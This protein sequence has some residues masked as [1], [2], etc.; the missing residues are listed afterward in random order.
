[1]FDMVDPYDG[2]W[3]AFVPPVPPDDDAVD[4][5]ECLDPMLELVAAQAMDEYHAVCEAERRDEL[6]ADGILAEVA[7][8]RVRANL[9]L[10][11][12]LALAAR[13]ADLHGVLDPAVIIPGA[14]R[15]VPIGGDG[16]PKIAEFAPAEFGAMLAMGDN[17]AG[18][19]IGDALDL[20]H[21]F[22]LLWERDSDRYRRCVAGPQDR[23]T[24]PAAVQ[25][26]RRHGRRED[27][28]AG[29]TL[30]WG[31]LRKVVDAAILEADPPKAMDDAE[32]AASQSGARVVDDLTHGYQTMIINAAA[33]DIKA[34]NDI[35]NE[36]SRALNIL[37]DTRPRQQ[38]RASAAG[39]LA[40][41]Q[42]ALDLLAR[43]EQVRKAQLEAAAAR[44][45]G[46]L[47]LAE[48][49]E[50][51]LAELMLTDPTPMADEST[52]PVDEPAPQPPRCDRKPLTFNT[53]V[54]YYHLTKQTLDA[55][56]NGEPFAGA[57][58]VRM[59]DIG[60]VIAEQVRQWLQHSNVTVKPVIDLAGIPPVDRYEVP[61]RISEA[62]G[63]INPADY[64]PYATNLS[65]HQ[66]NDHTTPYIPMNKGGPPGQT[67]PAKMGK[68]TKRHH[69]IKTHSG[70]RVEQVAAGNWL[71]RSPHGYHFLVH[72]NGTTALGKL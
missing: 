28:A 50:Q 13:W 48:R 8:T 38:R 72:P 55:M 44:R 34:L 59:E 33:G 60:P 20:R 15:L 29:R 40:H 6:D 31:R 43:A 9:L 35:L 26:S 57:G 70:W 62:I 5:D 67:D 41:P 46:D 63:L 2:E 27:R 24:G 61:D 36:L 18:R 12:Q 3:D 37:G 51:S 66:E 22:P 69:R 68:L 19:L 42:A 54:L 64:F 65:R 39:I 49:I 47:D 17:A 45:A 16:T 14:E 71:W 25:S 52:S 23:P 30:T 11:E 21:R 32:Q 10:V 53:S 58:V 56:L 7:G 1:M 4:H